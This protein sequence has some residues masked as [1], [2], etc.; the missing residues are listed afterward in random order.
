VVP[1]EVPQQVRRVERAQQVIRRRG[2]GLA[3]GHERAVVAVLEHHDLAPPR[4]RRGQPQRQHHGLAARAG[5]PEQRVSDRDARREEPGQRGLVLVRERH[6]LKLAALPGNGL[7][8]RAVAVALEQRGVVEQQVGPLITVHVHQHQPVRRRHRR[9]VRLPADRL[10][11][12]PVR[13]HLC[14]LSRQ[15]PRAR[16]GLQEPCRL[17]YLR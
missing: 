8:H 2:V 10:P 16:T 4:R 14:G 13:H 9:G 7:C 3:G 11:R 15:H 12:D 5:E 17:P 1:E 6:R